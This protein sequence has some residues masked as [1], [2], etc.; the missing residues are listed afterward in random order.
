MMTNVVS[1][2]RINPEWRCSSTQSA[3]P[4]ASNARSGFQGFSPSALLSKEPTRQGIGSQ[5]E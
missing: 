4:D 5:D 1:S 3:H 2:F